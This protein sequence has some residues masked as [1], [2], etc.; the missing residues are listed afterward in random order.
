MAIESW[1]GGKV[2]IVWICGVLAGVVCFIAGLSVANGGNEVDGAVIT[3]GDL[4]S[5]W[6]L[7]YSSHGSGCRPGR[8]A[9]LKRLS[10]ER[11]RWRDT[12]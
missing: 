4:W 7:A 8:T 3:L 10:E 9:A 1:H 12:R 6:F 2:I 11:D 5:S